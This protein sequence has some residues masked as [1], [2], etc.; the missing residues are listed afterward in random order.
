M[1]KYT[2]F[3]LLLIASFAGFSQAEDEIN[4]PTHI[5]TINFKGH[6]KE[7]ELPIIKLNERLQLSFDALNGNEDDF[8]YIIDHYN[9][10]WTPSQLMKSEYLQGF[11]NIRITNYENSFNTYQIYSHYRLQIPNQQTRIKKSG[12]YIIK[13]LDDYGNLVFSRKFM[14]YEPLANV[15]VSIKRSRNVKYIQQKQSVDFKI[16]SPTILFNNPNQ[17]VKVAVIQ[18]NNLNT[19]I[20]NLKPQYTLGRELI[21]KYDNE[22]SFWGGNEYL[23]FENKNVRAANIGV[24]YIDLK[25]IY[26][27]YLFT[28][29][30]RADRPYTYAPDINGNYLITAVDTDNLDIE[31]DYTVIH[32]SLQHPEMLENKNIHVYGSFNN[33]AITD[34]TKMVFNPDSGFYETSLILKQ[35]FY[36]Y[37]YVMID[38]DGN[39]DE[40]AISGN[41]DVT[42]NNYKVLVYYRNLG[43]RYDRLVGVGEGS[44]TTI[45][46]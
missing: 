26:E 13:I 40:G 21:Y 22:S 42:E 12:N 18:N 36:N 41:F 46:N 4:P 19:A 27:H 30:I 45:T 38:S 29:I 7:S 43:A 9:F 28:D 31:A 17:T 11:D 5:K 6:T 14:V 24:Q 20:T 39:L 2:L 15:G 25:D 37:K 33:Y 32:F 16:S 8:Y 10:D 3:A 44:S 1:N 35:G 23:Y 34:E